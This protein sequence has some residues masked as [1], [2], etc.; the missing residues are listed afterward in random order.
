MK[1]MILS[2]A[3]FL[4]LLLTGCL[5]AEDQPA[6]TPAAE[7][8]AADFTFA[9]FRAVT[10]TRS[11]E[12]LT[13][14][15][16]GAGLTL[17]M[18]LAGAANETEAQIAK[19]LGGEGREPFRPFSDKT[20]SVATMMLLQKDIPVLETFRDT[21]KNEFKA[22]LE[23]VDFTADSA[24]AVKKINAWC[25]KKTNGKIPVLFDR[26][27]ETTRCVLASALYF[28][29]DWKTS[30]DKDATLDANFTL[31]DGT[32]T[33]T[34]IMSRV[35]LMNF[36]QT[37]ET[38]VLELPYKTE[39]YAMFLLLPKKPAEFAAWES[40]VT[41]EKFKT[42]RAAAAP[43]QVN[44]RMP[45]FTMESSMTLNAP[46]E[47]LGISAAFTTDADFSKINGHND[48]YLSEVRQKTFIKVDETGTE[49]AAATAAVIAVKSAV[50]NVQ[51]FYA[52]RPFLYA[53]VKGDTVLFLG[54][55]VKPDAEPEAPPFVDP[56]LSGEAGAF[57]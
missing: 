46:L 30:F 1:T 12:N 33:K 27:G 14:S 10:E 2:I 44:L 41:S 49:A 6:E 23:P 51:P 34:K 36:G 17:E 57:N 8:P 38:A 48:L 50:L 4:G 18:V 19:A 22:A 15:P 54:R 35:G 13:V 21:I 16:Y 7:T 28:A 26:F 47:K 20:L 52:D 37:D 53:I 55:F 39:G 42:L 11:G 45:R 43:T 56:G 24:E 5:F 3:L 9:L 32:K 31:A 29:A 40:T 25:S